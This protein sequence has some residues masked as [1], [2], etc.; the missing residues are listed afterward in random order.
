MYVYNKKIKWNKGRRAI[1]ANKVTGW[2]VDLLTDFDWLN[3]WLAD[4]KSTNGKLLLKTSKNVI[5][6]CALARIPYTNKAVVA[7]RVG[8]RTAA[9]QL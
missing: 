1:A 2:V 4:K 8:G 5:Y 6:D 7:K 9:S 3:D